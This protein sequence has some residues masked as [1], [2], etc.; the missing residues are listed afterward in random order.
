MSEKQFNASY[1]GTEIVTKICFGDGR[2]ITTIYSDG[3]Y[4]RPY[5]IYSE[6]TSYDYY[7]N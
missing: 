4:Y 2:V 6:D 7:E 1:E 5:K 3:S